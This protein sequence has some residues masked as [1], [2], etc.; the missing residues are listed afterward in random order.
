MTKEFLNPTV[1]ERTR[2]ERP[3]L[4][5]L[6]EES[7]RRFNA[8]SEP[9]QK[10]HREAQKLSFARAMEPI[11]FGLTY[12]QVTAMILDVERKLAEAAVPGAYTNQLNEDLD[13]LRSAPVLRGFTYGGTP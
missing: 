6:I 3:E 13:E 12:E 11:W 4:A 10:A 7:C 9:E 8:L 2:R 5:R 1:D